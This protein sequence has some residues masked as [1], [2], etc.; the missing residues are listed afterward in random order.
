[1][2]EKEIC[3]MCTEYSIDTKCD[4]KDKCKLIALVRENRKLKTELKAVKKELTEL[5]SIRSWELYPDRM[6]K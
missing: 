4:F 5:K 1:M 2:T 6:G 3:Q